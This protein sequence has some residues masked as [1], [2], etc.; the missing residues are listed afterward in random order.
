M[1]PSILTSSF[2]VVVQYIVRKNFTNY[3][4]RICS[5]VVVLSCSLFQPEVISGYIF[6]LLQNFEHKKRNASVPHFLKIS[7]TSSTLTSSVRVRARRGV[8]DGGFVP[9]I[10]F[11]SQKLKKQES[12]S[13]SRKILIT[14]DS[15]NTSRVTNTKN[16]T[17]ST[18]L[19]EILLA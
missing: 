9:K 3:H 8:N 4:R 14:F 10:I 17:F 13:P 2:T 12:R 1:N 6:R 18:R 16:H 15:L 19:C 11:L 5:L 7:I